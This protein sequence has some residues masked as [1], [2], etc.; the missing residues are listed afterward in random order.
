MLRKGSR[1]TRLWESPRV[2]SVRYERRPCLCV[3][4]ARFD[5]RIFILFVKKRI[6]NPT[7]FRPTFI[8]VGDAIT[9]CACVIAVFQFAVNA[10]VNKLR[11]TVG[12]LSIALMD[13]QIVHLR[14]F[15]TASMPEKSPCVSIHEIRLAK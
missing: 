14:R 11:A 15:P 1:S 8:C 9:T 12:I 7:T 10:I 2:L 5:R 6:R 4:V 13:Y 3:F